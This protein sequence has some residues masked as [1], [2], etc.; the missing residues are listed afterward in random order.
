M[1]NVY[2]V[3]AVVVSSRPSLQR[4]S[5]DLKPR[6]VGVMHPLACRSRQHRIVELR[7]EAHRSRRWAWA[8]LWR[9]LPPALLCPLLIGLYV[10]TCW[11]VAPTVRASDYPLAYT[12]SPQRSSR[13]T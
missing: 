7:A 13:Q 8:Y 6:V 4:A 11:G 12:V 3:C 10:N 5:S 1:I 2:V 9:A